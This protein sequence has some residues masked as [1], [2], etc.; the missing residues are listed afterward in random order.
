LVATNN[1]VIARDRKNHL[2]RSLALPSRSAAGREYRGQLLRRDNLQLRVGAVSWLFVR[3]PP[4]ELG[5]MTKA[6]ALHVIVRDLH[7]KL[8][9]HRF[10]G[11][12]LTL[13]PA[14]LTTGHALG[15]SG[16]IRP[17][18]VFRPSLPGMSGK[19]VSSIGLEKFR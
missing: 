6:A 11:Q 7:H 15:Y 16:F 1:R 18:S 19:R 5:Y 2:Y 17:G 4:S 10:P 12:I 13:T 8:G 14:A 3:S 9:S